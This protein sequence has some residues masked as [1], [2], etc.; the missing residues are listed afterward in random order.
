LYENERIKYLLVHTYTPDFTLNN[1]A[2]VE[3]K[4]RFTG[5]DRTKTKE[6]LNAYPYIKD[7]FHILFQRNNKLSKKSKTTYMDWC[8]KNDIKCAVGDTV[9]AAWLKESYE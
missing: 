9:P 5:K 3:A 1:G 2:I 7:R 8:K 6:V 4:G